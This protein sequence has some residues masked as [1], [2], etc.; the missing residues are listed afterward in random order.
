MD[1][2]QVGVQWLHVLLGIV[3]FG[4]A[5]TT[6][7]VFVPALRRLPLA[8]QGEIGVAYG[9]AAG[10]VDRVAGT[11]V[12]GLGILR[13]IVFGPIQSV[14]LLSSPYGLTWLVALVAAV[15]TYLW[16]NRVLAPAVGRIGR[17]QP[18]PAVLADGSASPELRA[19]IAG[20]IRKSVVQLL[21][22]LVAFTCMILMR[23]GM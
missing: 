8:R 22:F 16:G 6:N 20:A 21:G 13:G 3:W 19:A 14:A 12:I 11:G 23:F 17:L 1:W 10:R 18:A 9:E 2:L 4:A 7:L 15:A 5:I